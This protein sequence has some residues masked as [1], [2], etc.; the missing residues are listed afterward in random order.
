MSR[1]DLARARSQQTPR[2]P[3]KVCGPVGDYLHFNA[4]QSEVDIR[5][6]IGDCVSCPGCGYLLCSCPP[7]A[8]WQRSPLLGHLDCL[9]PPRLTEFGK[10]FASCPPLEPTRSTIKARIDTLERLRELGMLDTP[11]QREAVFRALLDGDYSG[12][13]VKP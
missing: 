4:H 13:G 9:E 5:N 6:G 11:G 12:F 3:Y 10:A 8:T 2:K 7:K 1:W